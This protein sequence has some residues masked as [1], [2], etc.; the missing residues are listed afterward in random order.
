MNAE[1]NGI[2]NI[3]TVCA[4]VF[5]LLREYKNADKQFDCIVLDPPAFTKTA[6]ETQDALR[7]Y[8]D[9]NTLGIATCSCSH[10]VSQAAFERMLA[11]AARRSGRN[12]QCVEIRSQGADHPTLLAADETHYLKFFVLRVCDK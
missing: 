2:R 9:I 5:E 8:A 12:V 6:H 1:L 10:Y 3:D 11:E 4:D 7:G